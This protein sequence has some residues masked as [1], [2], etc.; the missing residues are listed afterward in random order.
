MNDELLPARMDAKQALQRLEY[1]VPQSTSAAM[2]AVVIRAA[3]DPSVDV[4]KMERLL[5]MQER[6]MARDAEIA[7]NDSMKTVQE[8]APRIKK[9]AR[10]AQTNSTYAR[11]ES[12]H[13]ALVPLYTEH[14]FSLS[15]GSAD[16]PIADHRRVTC[17]VSHAAGHSRDYF[18]DLPLDQLGA[19]GNPNKT[20]MHAF[21]STISY[22]RRYLALMIFNVATTDDDDG[23]A[24]GGSVEG[25]EVIVGLKAILWKLLLDHG[26]VTKGQ[27]WNDARQF[28][29]DENCIPLEI[30]INDLTSD[31][32][33]SAIAKAKKL[34]EKP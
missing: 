10:N 17:K 20:L 6:I 19:K 28:L 11:L 25:P 24:A 34:L 33:R 30:Q 1:E 9:D 2:L 22:G 12:V 7:F 16:C 32:F 14:G 5:A 31:Q 8:R 27:G 4:N 18:L 15:Y 21:G 26:Q 3:A 23:N 29:V 13:K